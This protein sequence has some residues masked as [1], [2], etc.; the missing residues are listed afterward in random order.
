MHLR[1]AILVLSFVGLFALA[2]A[3]PQHPSAQTAAPQGGLTGVKR[4]ASQ[5]A[6]PCW[7]QAGISKNVN[8]QR[9]SIQES[10]RSQIQTVC[11]EPNLS[12]QQKR[13]EIRKIRQATQEKV[14]ALISPAE[15]EKLEACQRGNRTSSPHSGSHAASDPCAGVGR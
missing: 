12:E 11:S 13:E 8:E 1:S 4:P 9:R 7:E 2:S 15:R 10:T 6:E 5:K 14:N 3:A